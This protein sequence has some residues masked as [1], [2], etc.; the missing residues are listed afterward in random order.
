MHHFER[1]LNIE[2]VRGYVKKGGRRAI[3]A[4]RYAA[5]GNRHGSAVA[6]QSV[7]RL[8]WPSSRTK[9]RN[10]LTGRYRT[11]QCRTGGIDDTE[12]PGPG[13]VEE[14][15]AARNIP[16]LVRSAAADENGT[17]G[18]SATSGIAVLPPR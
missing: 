16:G 8:R 6:I 3:E 1:N 13:D 18:V 11:N 9:E 14:S 5:Q 4:H 12:S 7:D 2:L 15:K 10:K 17:P